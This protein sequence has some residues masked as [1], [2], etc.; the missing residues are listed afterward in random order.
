MTGGSGRGLR[1]LGSKKSFWGEIRGIFH[2]FWGAF[3]CRGCLG[4]GGVP[5]AWDGPLRAVG[6]L[7]G[8]V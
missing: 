3:G 6:G 4:P 2:P 7:A 8:C 5:L 1:Y